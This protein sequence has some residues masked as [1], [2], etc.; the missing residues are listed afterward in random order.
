MKNQ[1]LSL[2]L[3]S[4][5]VSPI[6]A[7]ASG[8]SVH[9]PQQEWAFEGIPSSWDKA[10]FKRGYQVATEVCLSCHNMKYIS[11]RDM[12]AVGFSENEVKTM[13]ATVDMVINDKLKSSLSD[14]DAKESYGNPLPDLSLITKSRADGANYVYAILTGYEEEPPVELDMNLSE[15]TYY[16]HYFPGNAIAMPEPLME[17]MVEYE[18]GTPATIEQMSKDVVYFLSWASE[19]EL[20]ER[21]Q[22]GVYILIY[23]TIFAV[24]TFLLKKAVWRDVKNMKK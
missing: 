10:T 20:L 12:I 23:L 22:W 17:D 1:F 2:A 24:L 7:N 13:A 4:I 19:P 5:L 11:H 9:I 15:G 16:N 3:L 14:A 21:K 6:T 18:D 8:N